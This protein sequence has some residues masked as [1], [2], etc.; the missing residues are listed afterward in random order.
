MV[1]PQAQAMQ[2]Q[3]M[4]AHGSLVT[5]VRDGCGQGFFRGDDGDCRQ[6]REHRHGGIVGAILG[7]TGYGDRR[8][9]RRVCPEG[10]HLGHHSGECRPND[11]Q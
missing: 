6:E 10:F 4:P 9:E 8:D 2:V 5:L 3:T 7:G 1:A 11:D